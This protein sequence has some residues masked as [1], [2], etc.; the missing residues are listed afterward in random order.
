[1]TV[2]NIKELNLPVNI[3][4]DLTC[5]QIESA[6]E[7]IKDNTT[8]KFELNDIESVK[9]LP[10]GTK[11]FILKYIEVF[12]LSAGIVSESIEGLSQTF[13]SE[14][15]EKLLKQYAKTFLS[16]YLKPNIKFIKI[17]RHWRDF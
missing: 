2:D 11:L 12:S 14:K 3:I 15:S 13:N 7:W 17:Q 9:A 6:L 5:L 1:M 8:L 4:N 10:V 16:K